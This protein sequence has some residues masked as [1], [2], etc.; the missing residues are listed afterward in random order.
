[1]NSH[2]QRAFRALLPSAIQW[3]APQQ[4]RHNST[5]TGTVGLCHKRRPDEADEPQ[6]TTFD[7]WGE[8]IWVCLPVTINCWAQGTFT[9]STLRFRQ[10]WPKLPHNFGSYWADAL[11]E[12]QAAQSQESHFLRLI[13][14]KQA[15]PLLSA[16]H[17][18]PPFPSC[19]SSPP[20]VPV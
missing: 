11:K 15:A 6:M 2:S 7:H 19:P 20:S 9:P 5:Q 12:R 17:P 8:L 3:L 18:W 1:M 4:N 14:Y 13:S 10:I 16:V